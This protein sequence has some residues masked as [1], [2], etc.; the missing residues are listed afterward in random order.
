M[1][2]ELK[3]SAVLVGQPVAF[4]RGKESAIAK[5]PI[6]G[7]ALIDSL[8]IAGDAQADLNVHGGPDKA[9]H[10]YPQDH[11]AIWREELSS[12][13]AQAL[14]KQPG[15]FGENLAVSGTTEHDACIG[16]LWQVGN[17]VLEVSQGR[18]PCWKLNE[19]FDV[20]DLSARVQTS[21]RTGW[22][23]RVIETG[24]VTAGA[25]LRLLERPNPAFSIA[26]VAQLFYHDRRNWPALEAL[27]ALPQLA[28]SW[29]KLVLRR[30]ETHD[31]EDWSRRLIGN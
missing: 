5:S 15:A 4:A 13:K 28:A 26:A 18:Q 7:E 14:L 27:A 10:L 21:C 12:T 1:T 25:P 11:Y 22:Y 20:P 16:D 19:R 31:V 9:V 29:R 17:A 3:I 2:P 8:G 30:L 23:F 24:L 6:A